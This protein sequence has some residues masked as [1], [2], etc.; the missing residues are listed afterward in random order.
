MSV[1]VNGHVQHM[2]AY[3]SVADVLTGRLNTPSRIPE[4]CGLGDIIE[5]YPQA[6]LPL[7]AY[8]WDRIGGMLRYR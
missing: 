5:L 3:Y 6:K 1:T 2:I 8:D 7:P 4:S